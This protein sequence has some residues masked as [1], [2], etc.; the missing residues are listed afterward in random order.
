MADV[1]QVDCRVVFVATTIA[2][3]FM[4][5]LAVYRLPVPSLIELGFVTY[6]IAA[7]ILKNKHVAINDFISIIN[8]WKIKHI[9]R[10]DIV[11]LEEQVLK[12]LDFDVWCEVS[13]DFVDRFEHL[14]EPVF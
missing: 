5:I 1:E 7:K 14:F 3:K 2:D 4:A 9:D 12:T 8:T 6:L 11:L 10:Q 13:I